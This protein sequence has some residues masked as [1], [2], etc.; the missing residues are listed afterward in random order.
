VWCV[1]KNELP[2][3]SR[4]AKK[5]KKHAP[6]KHKNTPKKH[7]TTPKRRKKYPK[8]IALT[9]GKKTLFPKLILFADTPRRPATPGI[10]ALYPILFP[11]LLDAY[12]ILLIL[13]LY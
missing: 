2:R 7:K 4:A 13:Q 8:K 5:T 11:C 6:Q 9:R 1:F 3:K 12:T 10:P